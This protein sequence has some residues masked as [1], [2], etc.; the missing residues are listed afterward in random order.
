MG[1][2]FKYQEA[3]VHMF[4]LQKLTSF[5][6]MGGLLNMKWEH[7]SSLPPLEAIPRTAV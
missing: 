4:V 1:N 5:P 7:V 6:L 2:F 3:S